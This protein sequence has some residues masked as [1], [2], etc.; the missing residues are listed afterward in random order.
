MY[1]SEWQNIADMERREQVARAYAPT[2]IFTRVAMVTVKLLTAFLLVIL[3]LQLVTTCLGG[4]LIALTLGLFLLVLNL[5]W[6][7]I[8][9]LVMGTSWLWLK[10][11][12]LRPFLLLPG[13]AIAVVAHAY[14][15][16]APESERDAKHAKLMLTDSWP[17]SW[18]LLRPPS[19]G[20]QGY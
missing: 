1:G 19:G 17:L 20:T 14:V 7:P 12:Y 2:D 13:I 18:Y 5:I 11:W 8:F 6:L 4:C 3:P 16:L 10:A 15:M 9:A